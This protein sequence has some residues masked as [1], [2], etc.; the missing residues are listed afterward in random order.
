MGGELSYLQI[1]SN[2]LGQHEQQRGALFAESS[3]SMSKWS[4]N[5]SARIDYSDT[6]DAEFS[7]SIRLAH[8]IET[9]QL[10]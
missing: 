9:G 10:F 4:F 5:A 8:R 7:P 2:N 3:H 1:D 6:Y